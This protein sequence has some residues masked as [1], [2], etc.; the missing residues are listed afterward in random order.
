MYPN[1]L[2]DLLIIVNTVGL[3]GI[4]WYLW[5]Q[6]IFIRKLFPTKDSE[7]G[8][9]YISQELKKLEEFKKY[10][11][12]SVQKMSMIRFNPYQDTG[13]SQSFAIALLDGK[14]DGVVITS[15]HART[16]TRVYA[17]P[18]KGGKEDGVEFAD[19]ERQVIKKALQQ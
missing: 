15:L 17:K 7:N 13:G 10:S 5:R 3:L 1:W 14:N 12:G 9:D 11:L 4:A 8:W 18:V 16:S 2:G 6:Q 19:E